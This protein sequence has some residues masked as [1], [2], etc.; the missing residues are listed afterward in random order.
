MTRRSPADVCDSEFLSET[1]SG[2]VYALWAFV[3]AVLIAIGAVVLVA[4][5]RV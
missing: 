5:L 1:P 3:A 2:R 4:L